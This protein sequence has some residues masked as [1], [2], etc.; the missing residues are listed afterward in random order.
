MAII[1]FCGQ[2][3]VQHNYN[4]ATINDRNPSHLLQLSTLDFS[5][6]QRLKLP[7]VNRIQPQSN[8][9]ATGVE[10]KA[11]GDLMTVLYNFS[12]CMEDLINNNCLLT[13]CRSRGEPGCST[14]E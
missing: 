1:A 2:S 3:F 8:K 10:N 5:L 12:S 4:R 6:M 9:F 13:V 14:A 11:T 7:V